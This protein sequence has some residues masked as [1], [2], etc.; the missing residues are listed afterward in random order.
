MS[1]DQGPSELAPMLME[2]MAFLCT[3]HS[4]MYH[5][6]TN[7]RASRLHLGHRSFSPALVAQPALRIPIVTDLVL[8]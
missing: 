6:H 7:P 3:F 4:T 1:V 5:V 8:V 2:L